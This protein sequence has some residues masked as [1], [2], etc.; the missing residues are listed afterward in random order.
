MTGTIVP[1]MTEPAAGAA[2]DSRLNDRPSIAASAQQTV[3]A[4]IASCGTR[5]CPSPSNAL[6]PTTREMPTSPATTPRSFRGVSGSSRVI[7][8]VPRNARTGEAELRIV[9]RPA[10]PFSPAC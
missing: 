10:S 2:G 9:A 3:A 7:S 5:C 1:T 8:R 6:T 4:T